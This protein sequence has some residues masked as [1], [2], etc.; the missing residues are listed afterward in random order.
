MR[1]LS[2]LMIIYTEVDASGEAWVIVHYA[3]S[4]CQPFI[5]SIRCYFGEMVRAR[6]NRPFRTPLIGHFGMRRRTFRA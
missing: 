3:N 4:L 6:I 1:I 5:L 2:L